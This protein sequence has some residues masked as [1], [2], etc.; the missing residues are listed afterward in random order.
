MSIS[1]RNCLQLITAGAASAAL[2]GAFAQS[3][4]RSVRWLVPFTAG[5][6]A[7]I[8]ARLVTQRLSPIMGQNYVVENRSGGATI[9]ATQ[10]L[11][12][13]PADGLTVM[14]GNDALAVNPSLYPALP[15]RVDQDIEFATL[16][17]RIPMVLV[18]R[19]D[20]PARTAEEA[21]KYIKESNGKATYCTWGVGSLSHLTM[22]ALCDRL[23]VTM[24]HVPYQGT[25]PALKDL[26]GGMV[27][28]MFADVPG[29]LPMLQ[30]ERLR[31]LMVSTAE[32]SRALPDVRTAQELGFKD[33]NF[34]SWQGLILKKGVPAPIVEKLSAAARQVLQQADM[35]RELHTRGM[36]PWPTTPEQFRKQVLAD[37]AVMKA[38]IE[39]RK[40]S[41][42][43]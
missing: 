5:G 13:A 26:L 37:A 21:I 16:L 3:S 18:V 17:A 9:I 35:Q 7:D 31:P 12:N 4:D 8:V 19:P 41:I 30:A 39:K 32:R 27:D 6:G 23:G 11:L 29:A 10:A 34:L 33:F 42:K 36:D 20:F 24:T 14:S 22:E 15:Y 2:P 1:R 40:I 38:L 25:S 28:F 43:S